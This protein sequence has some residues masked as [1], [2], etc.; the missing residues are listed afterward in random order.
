MKF[1]IDSYVVYEYTNMSVSC[2][3]SYMYESLIYTYM[4]LLFTMLNAFVVNE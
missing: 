2:C 4:Y 3:S 1:A